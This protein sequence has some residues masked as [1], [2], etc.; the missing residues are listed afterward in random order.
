M[1]LATIPKQSPSLQEVDQV[2]SVRRYVAAASAPA[3]RKAYSSDW[4]Q[5]QIWCIEQGIEALPA[6]AATVATYV[7]DQ[8]DAGKKVSTL[9]RALVAISKAHQLAGGG[10]PAKHL[11]VK[12]T[13][14]GI[15]RHHF[16]MQKKAQPL[17]FESLKS[18]V[19]A[20]DF[21]KIRDVRDR[22]IHETCAWAL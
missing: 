6:T 11:V 13:M 5:F 17:L 1:T 18:V 20:M 19:A 8:A 3:T 22:A 12:E 14:K 7:A 4:R 9:E 15:R 21:E 10:D 16:A 2:A